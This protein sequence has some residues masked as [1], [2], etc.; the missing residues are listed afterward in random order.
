MALPRSGTSWLQ[1][2]LGLLPEI[3]T[4][5]ET[6][7][8]DNYLRHLI[9][10]W[11]NEQK[12][13]SPD[14]LNAILNEDEFYDAVKVFSDRILHKFWDFKPDAEIILEKTPDNLNF[15]TLLNRLYPQAY[16][17][18]V[19]R[20]PRAVVASHLALK[21][22]KWGWIGAEQNHLDIALK[23]HRGIEK[24]DRA[25]DL[26]QDRLIE[27]R[28]EDLKSDRNSTL[29]K[30]TNFLELDYSQDR[31]D[32]LIPQASATDLDHQKADVPTHSPF[33]DTRPNF[34]RRGEVDSWKEELTEAEIFD[35]ESICLRSMLNRGYK[36]IQ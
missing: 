33:F 36:P 7:L 1:G 10:S 34:F 9:K 21:K 18:H 24:S 17:I 5:R 14:G 35:I 19:V 27:I 15:V 13:L 22:E 6:H 16:F 11:D 31:L 3:A 23:W 4:V 8:V 20:D 30:I 28:Y 25:K 2:M 12:E 32:S 29:L 26:V